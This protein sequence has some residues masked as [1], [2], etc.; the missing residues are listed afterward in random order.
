VKRIEV[1]VKSEESGFAET[2]KEKGCEHTAT[3]QVDLQRPQSKLQ[4]RKTKMLPEDDEKALSIINRI[5]ED[6]K[7]KVKVHDLSTFQGK[8]LAWFKGVRKTPTVFIEDYKIEG[9]PKREQLL[10][11][12]PR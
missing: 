6:E 11:L 12:E 8:I 9:I 1:F 5:A 10:G 7:L 2:Y 3:G 4:F